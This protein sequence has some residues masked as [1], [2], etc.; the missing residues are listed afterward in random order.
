MSNHLTDELR[1]FDSTLPLERART[2]PSS[3][4][5][6]QEVYA[7]EKKAVFGSTWQMVGRVDQVAESG[8]YITT[9]IAGEPI[10]VIRDEKDVLRAFFNV[11]RHKATVVL[12]EPCGKVSKLRCRYHGWTYD[13]SGKLRGTPEF[14]GVQDFCKEDNGLIEIA[15]ATWGP[16]VWVHLDPPKQS[17]EAFL[18]PLPEWSRSRGIDKLKHCGSH[19]YTLNC[20]WKVYVDNYLDGGYH[21]NTVHP[22]LA[23]VLDYSQYKTTTHGN[24]SV[25]TSPLV[26]NTADAT[27]TKTRT[28]KEAAYWW[29]MPNF[30]LNLYEGVMDTNLVLPLGTDQ[31]KV[32]FDF[33]FADTEGPAAQ[34][35]IKDSIAVANQVQEEDM[36]ICEEVQRGLR[37]RSY[38]SGR[39]SVKRETAA[40]Y[41]HQLLGQRLSASL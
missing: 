4:Y 15:V 18:T 16:M 41:F 39:F 27:T 2:A 35:Y 32:I 19:S 33:Y 3:W 38:S 12:S 9:E 5:F 11:C 31:C 29:V 28:G 13:L 10:L 26:P 37:S 40:Y 6:D 24:T 25:Q 20:N 1:R 23:G 17:L 36:G 21:V 8:A 7:L 22:A 14:D 30:M 34:Q